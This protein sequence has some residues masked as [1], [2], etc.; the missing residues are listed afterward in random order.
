MQRKDKNAISSAGM[1]TYAYTVLGR[2]RQ[3]FKFKDSLGY[4]RGSVTI[5]NK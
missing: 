5:Q 1:V 3:Q 2:L 4:K